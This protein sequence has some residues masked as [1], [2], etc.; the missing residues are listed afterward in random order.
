[1]Q[2]KVTSTDASVHP[3]HAACYT[4]RAQRG[5]GLPGAESDLRR[6]ARVWPTAFRRV[7]F[8]RYFPLLRMCPGKQ[9]RRFLLQPTL[10]V[11]RPAMDHPRRDGRGTRHTV[12]A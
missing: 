5:S 7:H 1:M 2:I 10:G 6:V 4:A 3:S 12:T 9:S 11:S 8:T